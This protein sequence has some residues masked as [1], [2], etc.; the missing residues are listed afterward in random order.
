[1]PL[2]SKKQI[3][4]AR[5][6][7]KRRNE[8]LPEGV[9]FDSVACSAYIKKLKDSIPQKSAEPPSEKQVSYAT[10]IFDAFSE[11]ISEQEF[12]R[13]CTESG[14]CSAFIRR[15]DEAFN[16]HAAKEKEKRLLGRC[17]QMLNELEF[18]PKALRKA[19]NDAKSIEEKR[20][21]L[22]DAPGG[23]SG[24]NPGELRSVPEKL[25]GYWLEGM[26]SSAFESMGKLDN[27]LGNDPRASFELEGLQKALTKA[28]TNGL[29]LAGGDTPVRL[30][31]L[32]LIEEG[33]TQQKKTAVLSV[34]PISPKPDD[35][36]PRGY[37]W[38][39]ADERLPEFNRNL[40]GE[41][42][43]LP[44]LGFDNVGPF[45]T[46]AQRLVESAP[47]E[48]EEV[49]AEL[50]EAFA[51]WDE[52]FDVLSTLGNVDDG[53]GEGLQGWIVRFM[54]SRNEQ[55][56][57]KRRRPV[58]TVVDGSAASGTTHNVVNAF[59]QAL[60][61]SEYFEQ[62]ELALFRQIASIKEVPRVPY[63]PRI[64]AGNL[65]HIQQYAGHMDSFKDGNR[66]AFPL[67]PAQRDAL[68][69][70]TTTGHGNLLAVNGPP[71]TGKTSLLRAVIASM[72]IEPLLGEM[73]W[74]EC[75]LI[76]ACAATN[77]AVTNIISSFDET[78]GTYL[79]TDDSTFIDSIVVRSDSRWLPYLTSYGWYMPANAEKDTDHQDYQLIGRRLPDFAWKFYGASSGLN[80][81]ELEHA[82]A[83]YVECAARYF[84][85]DMTLTRA[86]LW[87]RELVKRE[88]QCLTAVMEA[89]DTWMQRLTAWSALPAWTQA[90][91]T[92]RDLLRAEFTTLGGPAGRIAACQ[93]QTEH[94][95]AAL[96]T[97]VSLQ[98]YTGPVERQVD[99]LLAGNEDS[100]Q[101]E[102]QQ[103]HLLKQLD[104]DL[105]FL[106]VEVEKHRH[107]TLLQRIKRTVVNLLT[108]E[109]MQR[110]WSELREALRACGL[111]PSDSGQPDFAVM[112]ETIEFRRKKIQLDLQAAAA[113][114]LR[115]R[116]REAVDLPADGTVDVT[117]PQAEV[118]RRV[119]Y[120]RE[121]LSSLA[122]DMVHL[123]MRYKL[124]QDELRELDAAHERYETAR[125]LVLS[126]RDVLVGALS[127]KQA[128]LPA[129][130]PILKAIDKA[131][132]ERDNLAESTL[133]EH[134]CE[135]SRHLQ[136]WLD[137][138][139]RPR[140][141]HLCAR[142][143]EGRFVQSRKA[144]LKRLQIDATF[145]LSSDKQL[146]ELAM[147][148]PVFVVTAYSAPKLMKRQLDDLEGDVPPY[149]FGEADLLIVDEAGQ[150][151]PEVGASTFLFAKRAIVVG[152]V[153]QLEPV[154]NLDTA[155][156]RLLAQRFGISA[157]KAEYDGDGYEALLPAG[158]LIARGSVMRMAQRST[159][160]SAPDA[161]A[162]GLTLTNHYRCLAPIIEICNR[163][164]YGDA[165]HVATPEPKS[166]WRPE[167]AR[168][169]YLVVD[170]AVD[171][172]N[173]GGSRRNLDEA[174]CIARWVK[175]N[176]SSLRRH[177]DPRGEKD[178][179]DIVAIV[180]PFKGQ[181][182]HLV[183]AVARAYG[184]TQRDHNDKK[185][186]Y[187]RMVI[188]TVH[189]LQGAEKPVVIFSMVE[190][191]QPSEKQFY[192]EGTNLIN[193]A[194]S[195]AKEMFI[196]AMT[197]KAVDYAVGLTEKKQRKP[198]DYLWR[199]VV[200]QGTRLNS[201]HVIVVESPN[202]RETIHAALGSSLEWE[203]IDTAG[204]I[205]QLAEPGQWD[206]TQA[207]EPVWAPVQPNGEK[208]LNRLKQL[209]PGMAS[210]Y[211]ATDPDPE[212]EAIAWH[213][214][215][216]LGERQT[217]GQM[218]TSAGTTPVVKR[219]RFYR[220]EEDEL[221]RAL[222]Q[223]S[224]GLDAGLVK[225]ALA[226]NFLDHLIPML[227]PKRLG[228]SGGAGFTAGI[229]RV[230]L[231]ILD[232]V[233]MAA[234]RP[235][236]QRIRVS[237][238][239]VGGSTLTA[240]LANR[241]SQGTGTV[242]ERP[243]GEDMSPMLEKLE[244][245]LRHPQTTVSASWF[246]R[247][248]Q[249]SPYPAI[250]TARLMALAYRALGLSPEETAK[251]LQ[252]LYEGTAQPALVRRAPGRSEWRD[253]DMRREE[254]IDE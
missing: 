182:E 90:H 252:A 43:K 87:L 152:D 173:P 201:R 6:I 100:A 236:W 150:G 94:W 92:R 197:Q 144:T 88:A 83:L 166:L 4:F 18:I 30:I 112:A 231:G 56:Q 3:D 209:W 246:G 28:P 207:T 116:A 135:L 183:E 170:S 125:S 253:A 250:N 66:K 121:R 211:L 234:L 228:M 104:E 133:V 251:E 158:V 218:P 79:F 68:I 21:V 192:D 210:L 48:D 240:W 169:G 113:L 254:T 204:H 242:T 63:D 212:G 103:Y 16:E 47:D 91:Q 200:Q 117:G 131:I 124:I 81:L 76:L 123:R 59:R 243:P 177:F 217:R 156:D 248:D 129:A 5:S 57:T 225:S 157:L 33:D 38:V 151:T 221:K 149:L 82:E 180:T 229:G 187:N 84:R 42:A 148:A 41:K 101:L 69:A 1:M 232:L 130:H 39:L 20:R 140:L 11:S 40:L 118:S 245:L 141:F 220:L 132:A 34:L 7:A 52:A 205:T 78:P 239:V 147:L 97:L 65:R 185:A 189:S 108:P 80:D 26:Q 179:S 128:E 27:M 190:S 155:T 198:S 15:Y 167:F 186:L 75:P 216:V 137:Q 96:T 165:L 98:T 111:T 102:V 71:G 64:E 93:L 215:R 115:M 109:E 106:A 195:R 178:L 244:N 62:P 9:E 142:Y 29:Q 70:L 58:F 138:H 247:L 17:R 54:L 249:R 2:P 159:R 208:A 164:V 193:V 110:T 51:L 37:R 168:L 95:D 161:R 171:T 139:V 61:D 184:V 53:L 206:I 10:S 196:V 181:K 203:V 219:M 12:Q 145:N 160:R 99:E 224:D 143:W 226:R 154:W 162:A 241:G 213:V 238:P 235:S 122:T 8:P 126:A 175:E 134:R 146:R 176:E 202:K 105:A 24:L 233:N 222:C 89:A 163:M 86:L 55:W 60:T 237:I 35:N 23:F 153:E 45:E 214:L 13:A 227:Y 223:A 50:P 46:W 14:L 67:D 22:S 191:T 172:K 31:V 188:D 73:D 194:V 119:D 85:R 77:Q 25:I 74:P 230:Q 120:A 44:G 114:V 72:W 36:D 32:K 174:S 107:A 199:A 136:D 49:V 19:Y 127:G